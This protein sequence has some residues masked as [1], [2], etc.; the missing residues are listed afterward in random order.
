[1]RTHDRARIALAAVALTLAACAGGPPAII[2]DT[3][4]GP[5]PL[6]NAA[7]AELAGPPPGI[8][9][10]AFFPT[11]G[12]GLDGTYAG[13]ADVLTTDGGLC[14][15]NLKVKDFRVRGNAARYGGYRGRIEPDGGLQMVYG[16]DWIIGQFEGATFHGQIEV[17]GRFDSPGCSYLLS[18]VRVGP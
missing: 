16:Q 11:P 3:A 5:V 10:A 7:S 18:L 8:E 13:T 4:A 15:Q 12:A 17:R 2:L 14:I 6:N 1:V 9:P